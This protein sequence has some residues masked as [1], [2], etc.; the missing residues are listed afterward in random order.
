[1]KYSY[2]QAG[3][4]TESQ[5]RRKADLCRFKMPHKC[6]ARTEITDD[7]LVH[8]KRSHPRINRWNKAMA[9]GLRHNF[10]LAFLNTLSQ[11][12]SMMYYI[13]NYATKLNTPTWKR[14]F[15]GASVVESLREEEHRGTSQA[16]GGTAHGGQQIRNNRTRQFFNRWANKIFSDR[17]LSSVEVCYHLL[18]FGTD[19][20]DNIDWEFVNLNTL[21]WTVFRRWPCAQRLAREDEP[22]QEPSPESVVF[23][24]SGPKLSYYAAYPHRGEA[25]ADLSFWEYLS[26]VSL[27]RKGRWVPANSTR[28]SFSAKSDLGARWVQVLRRP[29]RLATPVISGYLGTDLEE[30]VK[31]YFQR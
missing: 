4:E 5:S 7:G 3:V 16:D 14:L 21:Y 17:E 12:L 28:V 31:D 15:L 19:F 18:G 23:T 27:C 10:D 11:G 30:E 1:V 20:T 13:T 9:V 22:H 24:E 29:D 8:I 26:F 2:S 6:H 25:L